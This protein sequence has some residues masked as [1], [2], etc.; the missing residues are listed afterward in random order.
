M[1]QSHDDFE[2]IALNGISGECMT[3]ADSLEDI[4]QE[5]ESFLAELEA[6][7]VKALASGDWSEVYA[8]IATIAGKKTNLSECF[9]SKG[10]YDEVIAFISRL[11]GD[12]A[13]TK[14]LSRSGADLLPPT[15]LTER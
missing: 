5:H 1:T 4:R 3:T 11:L 2:I 8:H 6:L 15:E 14:S 10:E 13:S 12:E 7:A 9:D